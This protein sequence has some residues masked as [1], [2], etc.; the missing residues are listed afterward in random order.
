MIKPISNVQTSECNDGDCFVMPPDYDCSWNELTPN[1]TFQT[2]F[3]ENCVEL[4]KHIFMK[5]C[6]DD[7][8]VGGIVVG[9]ALFFLFVSVS[10][11]NFDE[12]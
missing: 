1:E 9:L 11:N 4:E 5:S 12:I 8:T 6:F 2:L 10:I 7:E 3:G